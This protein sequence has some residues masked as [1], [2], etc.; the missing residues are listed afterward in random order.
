MLFLL[1]DTPDPRYR[2]GPDPDDE[3]ERRWE[4][5]SSKLFL[6]AAGSMSCFVVSPFAGSRL[7]GWA[8]T[9][10]GVALCAQFVRVSLRDAPQRSSRTPPAGD[11]RE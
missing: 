1:V 2:G 8:L 5:I 4:P 11:D 3:R 10:T 6:P 7:A 9:A